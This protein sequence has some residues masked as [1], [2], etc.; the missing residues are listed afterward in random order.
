[1]HLRRLVFDEQQERIVQGTVAFPAISGHNDLCFVAEANMTPIHLTEEQRRLVAAQPGQPIN[2]LDPATDRLYVLIAQE[3]FH[4]VQDLIEAKESSPVQ[5]P[6]ANETIPPGIRR[7][8]EAYWRDL[9]ELLQL[10][11]RKRQ[12]VAYHGDQRIGFGRTS[13]ELYQECLQLHHLRQDEFYVDR[14]EPRSLP[15]WEAETI[16]APFDAAPA[17]SEPE[18]P[19]PS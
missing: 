17:T 2:L 19:T 5:P 9:P 4:Q 7:S 3:Q 6:T 14:L 16:D 15:P 8:Q 10:K 12:W 11:S 1:L 13:A 18:S